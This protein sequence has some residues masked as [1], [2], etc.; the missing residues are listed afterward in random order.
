MSNANSWV[1]PTTRWAIYLRD[2]LMCCYCGVTM[3][4]ILAV[5]DDNFLTLDHVVPLVP[6]KGGRTGDNSPANLVTACYACNVEKGRASLTAFLRGR[7]L[8]PNEV[9]ATIARVRVRRARNVELYRHAAKALLGRIPGVP[10]TDMVYDHDWLVKRQWREGD[11][12]GEY[13]AHIRAD[14]QQSLFCPTCRQPHPAEDEQRF[15]ARERWRG[16][17]PVYVPP[18]PDEEIPF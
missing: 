13:W 16:A 11:L 4:D 7:R 17:L 14:V 12:D 6:K 3:A 9:K 8:S 5:Y 15:A 2:D 1:Y 18:D 10:L